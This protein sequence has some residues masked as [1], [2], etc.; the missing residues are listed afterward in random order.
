VGGSRVRAGLVVAVLV[1]AACG[2]AAEADPD[3]PIAFWTTN[4]EPD[5]IARQVDILERFTEASG[6]AVELVP[7]EEDA[8]PN[9]I[10]SNAASGTLPEVVYHPLDFTVGWAQQGLLDT[11]AAAEVVDRLGRDTFRDRALELGADGGDVTAVPVDGWG[12]LVYYRTDLFEEAGLEPP[13]TYERMLTAAEALHDPGA[14][15]FGITAATDPTAVF[16]QQTFEHLALGNG[17]R[18][19]DDA[20]AAALDSPACVTAIDTYRQ[21]MDSYS[22]GSAQSDDTTRATY[23]AG[24]AGMLVWSPFLLDE[25]AGLRADALPNCPECAQDPRF[26]ADNTGVVPAL[27]GPD[28]EPA[29]YGQISFFGIG[30]ES[31]TEEAQA[32]VEYL[33]GDGYLDWLSLAPEGQFPMRTGT[34]EEPEGF[35][36]AWRELEIGVDERARLTDLYDAEVIDTLVQG[37]EQ[38]DRWG[39]G[40]GYGALV[41]AVYASLIV[42]QTLTAVLEGGEETAAAAEDL[43]AEVDDELEVLGDGR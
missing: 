6:I 21:L 19:V 17:C 20:G 26:L 36:E 25:L 16:T 8:L 4:I 18:L 12:Q 39:F 40:Q 3:A 24:Q 1:L 37:T 28:G 27:A 7:V 14:G 35:T 29:Q 38:F 32:L 9:L 41:S 23:F 11:A 22:P 15:R 2:G 43:A 5:R 42:P 30:A 33:V 10:V 13:D 31:R 34:A